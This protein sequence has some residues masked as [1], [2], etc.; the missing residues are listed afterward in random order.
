V[1]TSLLL[2]DLGT[3]TVVVQATAKNGSEDGGM[4]V[5]PPQIPKRRDWSQEV[6]ELAKVDPATLNILSLAI[7][8]LICPKTK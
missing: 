8:A 7:L 2:L 6:A 5:A 1:A 3:S 4:E